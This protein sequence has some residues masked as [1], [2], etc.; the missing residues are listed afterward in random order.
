[1]SRLVLTLGCIALF[2]FGALT[3]SAAVDLY[4]TWEGPG[5][6]SYATA[7]YL[8]QTGL[9]VT[10]TA[11]IQPE[12]KGAIFYHKLQAQPRRQDLY[13]ATVGLPLD[14]EFSVLRV[15]NLEPLTAEEPDTW[16]QETLLNAKWQVPLGQVVGNPLAPKLAVGVF[17]VSNLANRTWYGA[18]SR[19]FSLLQDES[20][21]ITLHLG[22]GKADH[23]E[24]ARLDGVFGGFDAQIS[25]QLVLQAEYDAKDLNGGVRWYPIPSLS[26]DGSVIG[27]NFGWGATLNN[28]F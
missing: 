15:V 12:L 16:R 1:M 20:T 18:I 17:D 10:P 24:D 13:G 7:S 26:L 21:M 27:G 28:A 25:K 4:G 8:G 6:G 14:L 19:S 9:I 22:F 11:M 2:C 23:G 3:A 5:A